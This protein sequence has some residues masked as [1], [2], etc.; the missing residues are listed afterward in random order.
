M[1]STRDQKPSGATPVPQKNQQPVRSEE[2]ANQLASCSGNEL[3]AKVRQ[4]LES[5]FDADFSQVRVHNDRPAAEAANA[6]GA[7]A[8]TVGRHIA[9]NEGEFK[10]TSPAG[11]RLL[12]HE[13]T[14]VVQQSGAGTGRAA[15]K[16]DAGAEHEADTAADRA[17]Q[18][19][20]VQAGAVSK[21]SSP[22]IQADDKKPDA[23]GGKAD[24]AQ[25]AAAQ[26]PAGT[27]VTVVMRAPDDQYTK[28]VT[29]YAKNTLKEQVIE[30]DNIDEAADKVA[31]YAK[32]NKVKVTNVRIIG[33]GSTTGGIKM[34]P[35]G[36]TGR[37]FVTAEEL[38]KMSADDKVKAKAKDAM[39]E[40][41]TVEFWGCYIGGADKSTKAVGEIFNAD[42][43][44]TDHTLRT[45]SDSF[46]RQADYGEKG[47]AIQGQK[48]TWMEAKS[49]TEIDFRVGKG[50][51]KLGESF[52]KW[53]V[54]QSKKLEAGGDLPPQPDDATRIAAMR[55]LFDRSGGKIKRLQISSGGETVERGDKEKWL[56]Q[57][58]TKKKQ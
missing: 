8:F 38:E 52:N 40:G 31:E 15:F 47:E 44:A 20:A 1:T 27:T 56:K 37:R 7:R 4:P 50:D 26:Q 49:T 32:K 55:D 9:F 23:G 22:R 16:R 43:K 3:P 28:D 46:L 17:L 25:K 51:K 2:A 21:S 29:D 14:H 10:P 30:V 57:W 11:Q 24:D 45:A 13:L 18:G 19:L 12:A 54:T 53:L 5:Q 36:E 48:G 33:H 39:A 35:K 6:L 42:V 58:K 41:A 34:T